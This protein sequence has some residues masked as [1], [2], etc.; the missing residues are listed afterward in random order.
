M[1]LAGAA[2]HLVVREPDAPEHF[3]KFYESE[4]S[5]LD[6]VADYIG[7]SLR[8]GDCG[9]VIA[10][11]A[12]RAGIEDR[13]RLNGL[14]PVT[15]RASGHYMWLNATEMLQRILVDGMPEPG[16]FAEVVGGVVSRAAE[17]GRHEYIFGEM[18]SLLMDEGNHAA[19]LRL[20]ALWNGLQLAHRFS[21]MCGYSM[22]SFAR[23]ALAQ[24]FEEVCTEHSRV[25]PAESYT[26]LTDPRERLRTIAGLQQKANSLEAEIAQRQQAE[27]RLRRLQ[28]ITGQL[29]QSLEVDRVLATIAQ[30]A[31]DLLQVPI[32]AVFLLDRGDPDA[33]FVLAA[34]FGIDE[35]QSPVLHLPRRASL[36]G[37]AVDEGRTLVVDDVSR[38]PGTALPALLTGETVGSE[39]AAPITSGRRPFGVVK[40]FSVQVRRFSPND[41]ALLTTLAAAAA[42]ALNNADLYR[43]AQ[44]AIRLRDE[45]LSAAA[46]DLKTPLSVIKGTAQLLRRQ[47]TRAEAP[48]EERFIEGLASID[49]TATQVA[50]QLDELL[51]LTRLKMGQLLELRREPADCVQL[52]HRVAR[53]QQRLSERHQICVETSLLELVG[54]W[55]VVRL[56]RVLENVVSNAVKYCPE[57]GDIV[58]TV[59]RQE[60]A[61]APWAVLSVRDHGLGIPAS[62]LPHIFERFRRA[63][64]VEGRTAGTGLGLT[65]ARQIVEQHG[66]TLSVESV[67]GEGSVFTVCLP[68]APG[69]ADGRPAAGG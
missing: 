67:E 1:E 65:S 8:K 53:E 7:A 48:G 31:A 23:E 39:I 41:A 24:V 47:R 2:M 15:A 34:A 13:L 42:V 52:A 63:R 46:H 51:D 4:E 45:F 58:L 22:E 30:S 14:D 11:V 50:Q 27:E 69:G 38:T 17:A 10:T 61:G 3:V 32:G 28:E 66:G 43:Q 19:A 56:G 44:D 49:A 26:A 57:G 68:L 33:D 6:A 60:I 37:R 16:L 54:E 5:L 62:D 12:H 29:S 9:L 21:L 20:E 40:A 18:V 64:N 36:A 25:L 59:A 55:D 35:A